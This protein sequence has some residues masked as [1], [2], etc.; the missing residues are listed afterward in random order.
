[1]ILKLTSHDSF[2]PLN[3][4]PYCKREFLDMLEDQMVHYNSHHMNLYKRMTLV[5]SSN[6]LNKKV[7]LGLRA[8]DP[9]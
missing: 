2:N 1:M 3:V 9:L 5:I 7:M 6:P 8:I 4:F